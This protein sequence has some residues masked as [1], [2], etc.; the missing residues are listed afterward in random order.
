M[1]EINM[2]EKL[3][4]QQIEDW[5]TYHKPTDEQIPKYLE[6]REQAKNFAHTLN[7][8]LPDYPNK[9]AAMRKLRE[10]VMTANAAIALENV[11]R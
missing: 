4:L 8:L 3:K 11:S 10:C 1:Q 9:S 5:F 7:Q 2:Q 6:I